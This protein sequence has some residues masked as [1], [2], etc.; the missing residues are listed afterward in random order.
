MLVVPNYVPI[1][2]EISAIVRHHPTAPAR[3]VG[4]SWHL[5][6]DKVQP[7]KKPDSLT[8]ELKIAQV[9]QLQLEHLE[10][11]GA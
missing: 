6:K 9:P 1:V 3:T 10:V 11:D 2:P 8:L 5:N 7:L 4:T